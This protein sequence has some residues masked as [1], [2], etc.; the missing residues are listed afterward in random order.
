MVEPDNCRLFEKIL[1]NVEFQ[2]YKVTKEKIKIISDYKD[3]AKLY[4]GLPVLSIIII[5]DDYE[6]SEIEYSR[7]S[8]DILRPIYI[9]MS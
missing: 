2:S 8:S 6:S 7:V 5:T 1:I 3:Y 4:Y 9:H